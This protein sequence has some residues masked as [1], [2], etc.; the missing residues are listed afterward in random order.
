M[1]TSKQIQNHYNKLYSCL[2]N[3]I[4]PIQ[5]VSDIADLEVEVYRSFPDKDKL[6]SVFS[7]IK[8]HC[9][10]IEDDED[11]KQELEG[12]GDILNK[13]TNIYSKLDKRVE[14]TDNEDK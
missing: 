3:Y 12:F 11:L 1:I 2:R 5:A 10:D 14:V 9:R 8:N 7:K 6:D 4:W 13:A